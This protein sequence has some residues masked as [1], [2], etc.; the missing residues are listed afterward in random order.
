M[1]LTLI[2]AHSSACRS[3]AVFARDIWSNDFTVIRTLQYAPGSLTTRMGAEVF[4]DRVRDAAEEFASSKDEFSRADD[5]ITQLSAAEERLRT[6]KGTG[7]DLET[8]Q[9]HAL[10]EALELFSRA[11]TG[12]MHILIEGRAAPTAEWAPILYEI[13]LH[14]CAGSLGILNPLV[15]DDARIAWDLAK[16]IRG[17]LAWEREPAGGLTAEFDRPIFRSSTTTDLAVA[18]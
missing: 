5:L 15:S 12:Q 13:W 14:R 18:S 6:A 17:H 8:A 1:K 11:H 10:R 2:E 4:G 9:A 3:A 7:L 16:I